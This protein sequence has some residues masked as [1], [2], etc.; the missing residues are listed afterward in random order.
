MTPM[1]KDF[2]AMLGRKTTYPTYW[3]VPKH[4]KKIAAPLPYGQMARED[5]D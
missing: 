3:C 1:D 2:I 5:R 4:T